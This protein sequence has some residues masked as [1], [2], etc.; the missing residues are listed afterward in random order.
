MHGCFLIRRWMDTYT[1]F[2]LS[3]PNSQCIL[4]LLSVM[5]R[6][7]SCL[8]SKMGDAGDGPNAL[9]GRASKASGV[10]HTLLNVR[11]RGKY[12]FL[13]RFKG[14]RALRYQTSG[15]T[16]G[17]KAIRSRNPFCSQ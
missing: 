17:E 4:V 11:F 1:A 15:G 2:F 5:G 3:V 12:M 7:A 16:A 14:Y 10:A 9:F 6:Y 8:L 13:I